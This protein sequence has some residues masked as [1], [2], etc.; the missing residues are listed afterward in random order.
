MLQLAEELA[1]ATNRQLTHV[2]CNNVLTTRTTCQSECLCGMCVM[3]RI[4]LIMLEVLLFHMQCKD[5]GDIV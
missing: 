3:S 5:I 4:K 2:E 1:I